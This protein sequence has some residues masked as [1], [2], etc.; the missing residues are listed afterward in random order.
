MRRRTFIG[1]TAAGVASVA[2]GQRLFGANAAEP[3]P[4]AF[5]VATV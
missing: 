3:I 1:A 5:L 4:V 2:V